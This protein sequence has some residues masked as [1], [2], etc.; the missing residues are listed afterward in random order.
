MFV[1]VDSRPELQRCIYTC[2]QGDQHKDNLNNKIIQVFRSSGLVQL[3]DTLD[4][5]NVGLVFG[6]SEFKTHTWD[7]YFLLDVII[8]F[9]A[10]L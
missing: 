1:P 6:S 2:W 5:A 7:R 10:S 8:D 3:T 4:T 9:E